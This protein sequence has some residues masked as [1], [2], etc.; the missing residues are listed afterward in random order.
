[1][2][3]INWIVLIVM[4]V[5]HAALG[6]ATKTQVVQT[7]GRWQLLRD[8]KPYVIKGVGGNGSKQLLAELG[9][10]SVRTWG[11]DQLESQLDEAK[12]LGLSMTVGIWLGQE[13][14]G[15]QYDDP[16]QVADQLDR[17]KQTIL[18]YKDYPAVLIWGIGNEMEGYKN[19]DNPKIWKAVND[20]AE[21]AKKIDPNHPTMT[22]IAEIGGTR[23]KCI[24]EYCPAIDIV[25]INSYGGCASIA[26]RYLEAGGK[27][28]YV[29]TEFG[30]PGT[31]EI[32]KTSY[33]AVQEP[34]STQKADSYRRSYREGI[35]SQPGLCLGS[36][37]FL[38]G[39][40]QEGTLSWF[41]ML[42]PEGEKTEAAEV[43]SELWTGKTPANHAPTIEPLKLQGGD[44]VS[45]GQTITADLKTSDPEGDPIKVSWLLTSESVYGTGGDHE[46]PLKKLPEAIVQSDEKHAEVKLP[47]EAGIYRLYAFV[48]DDHGHCA[49][50]NVPILVKE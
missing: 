22:V 26:K 11:A 15:F 31:W 45:P 7:D 37:A 29:I 28:P 2:R 14:Q 41:G 36:Y 33:G 21:M 35:A 17:A 48:R 19:G 50:A 43:M 30:P 6:E 20:I 24:H 8:G 5:A 1:M 44:T 10:N 9:G 39:T 47:K 18:K 3:Q 13:R 25:G 12:K 42:T 27:K 16:K 23:V 34:T 32:P 38:W 49:V 46:A 40:K 4:F